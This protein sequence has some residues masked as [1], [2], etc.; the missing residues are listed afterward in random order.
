MPGTHDTLGPTTMLPL[1]CT[2]RERAAM[3]QRDYRFASLALHELGSGEIDTLA[4][5]VETYR[6]PRGAV[7][8]REGASEDYMCLVVEGE[9][10][11]RKEDAASTAR[12]LAHFG[13]GKSF[14]E[15]ALVDAEPRSA[16][17][18]ATADTKL[19]VLSR[20]AL[21]RLADE[22]PRLGV[23]LLRALTRL[24]SRRLRETSGRLVDFLPA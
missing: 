3:L 24:L 10:V 22:H 11:V 7:V 15:M 13:P 23:K 1:T 18:V 8:F 4:R 19:I 9:V 2:G 12:V 17:V 14:G 16:T 6:A 5:Y 21:E 20:A